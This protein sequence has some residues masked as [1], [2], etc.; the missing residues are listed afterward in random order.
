MST[1]RD[2]HAPWRDRLQPASFRGAVFHVELAARSSG[3]RGALKEYP[4][5]NTPYNED[6]GRMAR[7]FAIT[8]YLIGP[9]Y[10]NAR[11][12]LIAALEKDGP[13][14]LRLPLPYQG[15]DIKVLAGPYTMT[16][17]RERGGMCGFE[18]DF[19]EYGD[20]KNRPSSSNEGEVD[21]A[22]MSLEGAVIN[23]LSTPVTP[24]AQITSEVKPYL[25]ILSAYVGGLGRFSGLGSTGI[26]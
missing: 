24:P 12:R 6:M 11:D 19:T 1:I 18:M 7:R 16:E 22:S 2:I 4:K 9:N 14:M 8:G 17:T 25:D 23:R 3:R 26:F 5:R 20:P 21:K 13:G 10:L 15:T